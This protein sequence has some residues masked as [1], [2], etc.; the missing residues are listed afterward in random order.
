M[1]VFNGNRKLEEAVMYSIDW[2]I[3]L[4]HNLSGTIAPFMFLINGQEKHVRVLMTDGDPVEYAKSILSNEKFPFQQFVIGMEGYLRDD[5]N[6]RIDAIIVQGFDKTQEKGV[7]L[8][9]MFEPLEQN[10]T[11]KKIGRVTFLGNPELPVE[12]EK[13]E[14]PNYAAEEVGFNSMTL[15]FGEMTQYMA[16]FSQKN[17]SLIASTIKRFLRAKLMDNNTSFSGRFALQINPGLIGNDD[18][19]KFLVL[20]AVDEERK[21]DHGLAWEKNM[22]RKILF[23]ISHGDISYLTEFG[24]EMPKPSHTP[25]VES[26]K[27][28]SKYSTYTVEELHKDFYRIIS[29]PNA[30]TNL[31]ALTQM[32]ELMAEYEKR[33]VAMPDNKTSSALNTPSKPWWKFW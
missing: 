4:R 11:F 17:P 18:F 23:N 6:V 24:D 12:L 26:D 9:Q 27:K 7:V 22:G 30:R 10:G 31:S 5:N 1:D 29:I 19:L 28:E 33:G 13:V 3:F 14:H 8:A 21:S 15:A 16:F 25:E 32:A 2:G 20:T